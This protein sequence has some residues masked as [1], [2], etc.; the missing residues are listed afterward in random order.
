MGN[1]VL[2]TPKIVAVVLNYKRPQETVECVR[3]L[4]E[5]TY[6]G[7]EIVVVDNASS[8]GSAELI[9]GL[10][11]RVT[12]VQA[13]KNLGY[14]GGMNLGIRRALQLSATYILI[15]NSDTFVKKDAL[16]LLV[17]E[18]G[19]RPNAGAASGTFLYYPETNKVWYA[20]G[21]LMYWQAHAQTKRTFPDNWLSGTCKT[22]EVSFLSGCAIVFR[23]QSL[24]EVGLFDE[25]YFMYLEDVDLS[26]RFAA[27]GLDL[28]YVPEAVFY[29][30]LFQDVDEP[31]KVYFSMRNRLLF[32]NAQRILDRIVGAV[33][34]SLMLATKVTLWSLTR[35]DLRRAALLGVTDFFKGRYYEGRGL[36]FIAKK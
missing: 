13:E 28:L 10:Y 32:L 6:E 7:V 17:Q 30:R 36:I 4:V 16:K 29:H 27:K 24:L 23:A 1:T 19:E 5:S 11:H 9:R 25:R 34:F 35:S 31:L 12:V 18:L 8:D 3:S 26:A 33:Y 20:G 2:T 15:I 14:A 21:K 22:E